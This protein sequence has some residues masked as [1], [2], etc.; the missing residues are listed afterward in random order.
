MK[1]IKIAPFELKIGPSGAQ[2]Q[3]LSFGKGSGASYGAPNFR[4]RFF[5]AKTNNIERDSAAKP[6]AG[7]RRD[8]PEERP[9]TAAAKGALAKS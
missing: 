2:D 1:L 3:D 5:V 6:K 8:C 4:G 9:I 7:Q